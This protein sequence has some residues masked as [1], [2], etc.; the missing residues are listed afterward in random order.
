M[1]TDIDRIKSILEGMI[2]QHSNYS[3]VNEILEFIN[4]GKSVGED[5]SSCQRFITKAY[6]LKNYIRFDSSLVSIAKDSIVQKQHWILILEKPKL[7]LMIGLSKASLQ[8]CN[9]ML[10]QYK[11]KQSYRTDFDM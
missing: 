11:K 7:R 6:F 1:F 4:E 2:A 3:L 10:N 9:S 8:N 5:Y